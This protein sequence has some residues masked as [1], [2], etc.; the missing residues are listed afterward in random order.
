MM[1]VARRRTIPAVP[2]EEAGGSCI[3]RGVRRFFGAIVL[4]AVIPGTG[5]ILLGRLWLGIALAVWFAMAGEVALG[6]WLVAPAV[7]PEWMTLSGAALCGAAW[8]LGQFLIVQ[9][10]R[11]L[12]DPELPEELA[13]LR[14]LA[15]RALARGN[16]K[17]ARLALVAAMAMDDTDVETRIV[18][19]RLVTETSKPARARRVW[20]GVARLDRDQKHDVE[21]RAALERLGGA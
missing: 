12:G 2:G 10:V 16:H 1:P 14:A 9:R 3:I 8:L 15:E 17:A 11:F 19:A 4:N 7:I 6:G 13:D 5:L 18:W 21:I 20:R